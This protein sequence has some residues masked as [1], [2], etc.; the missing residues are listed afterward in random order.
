MES[1][2]IEAARS[3]GRYVTD[4]RA[5]TLIYCAAVLYYFYPIGRFTKRLSAEQHHQQRQAHLLPSALETRT[6]ID[7]HALPL[8]GS[9]KPTERT[10]WSAM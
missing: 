3:P 9:I 7:H 6:Y 5:N 10:S 2:W 1:E 4:A 8:D